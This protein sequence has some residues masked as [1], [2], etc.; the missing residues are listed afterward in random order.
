MQRR[1][2]E[3]YDIFHEIAVEHGQPNNLARCSLAHQVA[4]IRTAFG[5][6]LV[7]GLFGLAR[8]TFPELFDS[9]SFV[10]V[11]LSLIQSQCHCGP[12]FDG[13]RSLVGDLEAFGEFD[14]A[15]F[16][17]EFVGADDPILLS[18]GCRPFD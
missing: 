7:Q 4:R 2:Q 13:Q 12:R 8:S 1:Q 11:D 14:E 18:P 16:G 15:L 3:T 10:V 9:P 5:E 6:V 17:F